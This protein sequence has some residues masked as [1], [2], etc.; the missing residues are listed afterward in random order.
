MITGSV[1]A[2]SFLGAS[3]STGVAHIAGPAITM[4]SS[5]V[6]NTVVTLFI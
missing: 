4:T 1:G 2:A 3:I 6:I 5:A